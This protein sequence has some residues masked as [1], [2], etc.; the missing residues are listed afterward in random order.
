[1]LLHP[2]DDVKGGTRASCLE[3]S[4]ATRGT[5]GT[6]GIKADVPFISF[7]NHAALRQHAPR[8]ESRK[9]AIGLHA[10][11]CLTARARASSTETLT[12]ST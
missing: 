11:A 4:W 7:M 6:E 3:L 10:N 12:S 5:S 1:M 2:T 9:Q 8:P